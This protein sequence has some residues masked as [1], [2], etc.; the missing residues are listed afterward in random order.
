M[1]VHQLKDMASIL[2]NR[3]RIYRNFDT[4]REEQ[5]AEDQEGC[6]QGEP[7][8]RNSQQ[9]N[10]RL[11]TYGWENRV[12]GLNKGSGIL[13]WRNWRWQYFI[14]NHRELLHTF[15]YC[16]ELFKVGL[17]NLSKIERGGL[18]FCIQFN[19]NNGFTSSPS[20]VEFLKVYAKFLRP[21]DLNTKKILLFE[22]A[23]S[24]W[25]AS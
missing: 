25:P 20:Y 9:E 22:E 14:R 5:I 2:E 4:M 17:H 21:R 10:Q 16:S 6:L 18:I 13:L 1:G 24:F 11:Q 7:G 23:S 19:D 15:A 8:C 3:I 12:C